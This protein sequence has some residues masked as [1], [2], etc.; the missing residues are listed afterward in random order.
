MPKPKSEFHLMSDADSESSDSDGVEYE[1]SDVR[2]DV[3]SDA[4][5]STTDED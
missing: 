5:S 4:D 2:S 1:Q 3:S